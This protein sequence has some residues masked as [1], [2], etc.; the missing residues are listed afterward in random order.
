MLTLKR[1]DT[2]FQF[3]PVPLSSKSKMA[4]LI[5]TAAAWKPYPRTRI[6]K[7]QVGRR[8]SRR[9]RW[10]E[11]I[12]AV[13]PQKPLGGPAEHIVRLIPRLALL[14]TALL[15]ILTTLTFAQQ[16]GNYNM[17][18][19]PHCYEGGMAAEVSDL[20]CEAFQQPDGL[21]WGGVKRG[22]YQLVEDVVHSRQG[23]NAIDFLMPYLE[24]EFTPLSRCY[25]G[26]MCLNFL[27]VY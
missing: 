14:F 15:A 11:K 27:K 6:R 16:P 3:H 25:L 17:W 8:R 22:M 12:R 9:P 26:M 1:Q 24:M 20:S 21:D 5:P 18:S 4:D 13:W 7:P 10:L 23:S 2:H 19:C